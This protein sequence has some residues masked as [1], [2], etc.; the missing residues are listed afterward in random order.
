MQVLE[1]DHRTTAGDPVEVGLHDRS[2]TIGRVGDR[3]ET[4]GVERELEGTAERPRLG[5][6]GQHLH[7]GG[8]RPHQL[9][10]QA[11]LSHTSLADHQCDGRLAC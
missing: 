11:G 2:E 3:V 1:D 9:A 5:L 8:K 4:E 6:A 10:Q 7:I